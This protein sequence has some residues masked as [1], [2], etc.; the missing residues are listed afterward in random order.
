M[1]A[2]VNTYFAR[3]HRAF[4]ARVRGGFSVAGTTADILQRYLFLYGIWEPHLSHWIARQLEPGGCF[5]DVGANVGY[6]SLLASRRVGARGRV[7]SIEASPSIFQQ[8]RSNLE[9]NGA[10]N[11]R[12]LNHA[13]SDAS[14]VVRLFRNPG[15]NLGATSTYQWPGYA[16]EAQVVALPLAEMV[17]AEELAGAR[18]VKIDVEGAEVSVVKGLLPLLQASRPDLEIVVEVGG[19]PEAAP[20]AAQAAAAIV[21][22]LTRHEFNVYTITNDYNPDAYLGHVAPLQPERVQDPG[23]IA[24]ECDLIFSRRDARHL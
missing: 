14:G 24:V 23:R 6:F 16:E 1:G 21:A 10:A 8:L 20:S 22:M 15:Y 7:V 9:L 2:R 11:V 5:V 17:T 19:G 13:A 3:Y 18:I 12:P 4:T